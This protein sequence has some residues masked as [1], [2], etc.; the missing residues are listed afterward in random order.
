MFDLQRTSA[1]R[2]G[3]L[4]KWLTHFQ[5]GESKQIAVEVFG[6]CEGE[7]QQEFWIKTEPLQRVHIQGH[8]IEPGLKIDY[9]LAQ[10]NILVLTFPKTFV[11]VKQERNVVIK[12]YSSTSALFC[13]IGITTNDEQLVSVLL[14]IYYL[15]TPHNFI[16]KRYHLRT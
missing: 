7:F 8:F 6:I 16:K 3:W 10:Q 5:P 13:V 9:P 4:V 2:F 14:T 11:G 1:T 12:N 15:Y